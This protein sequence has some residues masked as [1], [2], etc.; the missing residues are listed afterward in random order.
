M[1]EALACARQAQGGGFVQGPPDYNAGGGGFRVSKSAR[2][3]DGEPSREFASMASELLDED[4]GEDEV[5]SP[6]KP[7]LSPRHLQRPSMS[8][9]F[10]GLPREQNLSLST[11]TVLRSASPPCKG[12]Q[13]QFHVRNTGAHTASARL[14]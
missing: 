11:A 13:A 6:S 10:A 1:P 12:T 2:R 9:T 3:G 5:R 7:Y 8:R 4:L 14:A